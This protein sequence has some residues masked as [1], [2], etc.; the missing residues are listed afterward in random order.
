MFQKRFLLFALEISTSG[1]GSSLI[2]NRSKAGESNY[3]TA[4]E[5]RLLRGRD[6]ETALSMN[7]T[8]IWLTSGVWEIPSIVT[9]LRLFL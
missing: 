2:E 5:L 7:A 3:G 1:D 6:P 8:R 9:I 4:S